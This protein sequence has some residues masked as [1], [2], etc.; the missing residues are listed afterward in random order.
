MQAI[1]LCRSQLSVTQSKRRW[2]HRPRYMCSG[3]M[4]LRIH[5]VATDL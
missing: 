5:Q 1:P 4:M 3:R 2:L